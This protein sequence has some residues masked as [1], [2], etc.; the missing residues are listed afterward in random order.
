MHSARKA[1]AMVRLAEKRRSFPLKEGSAFGGYRH[2]GEFADGRYDC[3]YVVPWSLSACNLDADIM[4][5]AQD[6]ASAEFLERPFDAEM[7]RLGHDARLPSNRNLFRFLK[8]HLGMEFAETFATDVVPFI[9]SGGMS[10]RIERRAFDICTSEFLIPQI[11]IVEPRFVILIGKGVRDSLARSLG[12]PVA[13][14]VDAAIE[15]PIAIDGIPTAC[16]AHT[17]ARGMTTR[18]YAKTDC[19]WAD[20][21]ARVNAN[22]EEKAWPGSR[23]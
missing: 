12:Y 3:D 8:T 16:V 13:R 14:N 19:D 18:G 22:R 15:N 4:L 2:V 21:V 10:A 11:R 1:Q 17:G 23:W 9:K 7:A 6:W 5:V 20:L